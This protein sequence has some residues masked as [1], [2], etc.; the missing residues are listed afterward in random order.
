MK[1]GRIVKRPRAKDDLGEHF[2]YIASDKIEPAER[3]LKVAEEAFDFL[4]WMPGA[5]RAWDDAHPILC[6]RPHLVSIKSYRRYMI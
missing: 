6:P 5:G 4:A 2:A 1:R 3:F